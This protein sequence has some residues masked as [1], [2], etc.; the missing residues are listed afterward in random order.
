MIKVV[1]KIAVAPERRR[2]RK[3]WL[4]ALVIRIFTSKQSAYEDNMD[5][6]AYASYIGYMYSGT[7]ELPAYSGA[8]IDMAASHSDCKQKTMLAAWICSLLPFTPVL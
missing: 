6:H 1:L 5:D 3:N 7:S 4:C 2:Q 8:C